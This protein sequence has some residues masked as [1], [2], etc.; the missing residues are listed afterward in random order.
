M[1]DHII[2]PGPWHVS[3]NEG[4]TCIRDADGHIVTEITYVNDA[5]ALLI[6]ARPRDGGGTESNQTRCYSRVGKGNA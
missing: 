4:F 6:G 2:S 1:S 5:N 3:S